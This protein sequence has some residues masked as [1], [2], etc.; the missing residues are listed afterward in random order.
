MRT[1]RRRTRFEWKGSNEC[2]AG[3]VNAAVKEAGDKQRHKPVRNFDRRRYP[4]GR[5][6]RR[7]IIHVPDDVAAIVQRETD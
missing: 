1:S 5:N 3:I 2:V 4:A 7:H 6:K